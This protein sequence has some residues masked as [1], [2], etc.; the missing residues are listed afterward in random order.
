MKN[1]ECDAVEVAADR[2]FCEST[3]LRRSTPSGRPLNDGEV[4]LGRRAL[5]A[6][7]PGCSGTWPAGSC[8]A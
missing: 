8:S 7:V 3:S 6:D 1:E 2:S 4:E 5:G